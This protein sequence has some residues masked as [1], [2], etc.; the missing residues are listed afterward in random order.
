MASNMQRLGE[1]LSGRMKK[2]ANTAIVTTLELGTIN[3]NLSL[4]TDSLR[5]PIPKGDYMISITLTGEFDTSSTTHTHDGGS[6]GGHTS[7]SGSHTHS[8][9]EHTHRLPE[10]F[11]EVK[12]GDRV[13]VAWCGKEPVIISI[14]VSS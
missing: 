13:L 7:G 1:T 6:H 4:T 2:T 12:P 10:T 5:V 3:E 14:V 8:G 9:G 11:R